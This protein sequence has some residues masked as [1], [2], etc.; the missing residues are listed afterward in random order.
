MS[1]KTA[2]FFGTERGIDQGKVQ[3][4]PRAVYPKKPKKTGGFSR[5]RRCVVN[6][7]ARFIS[8]LCRGYPICG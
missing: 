3:I 5:E 6:E 1:W 7:L 2:R 4:P 8:M